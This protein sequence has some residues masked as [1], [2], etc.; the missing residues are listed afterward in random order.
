MLRKKGVVGKFV[1][2]FGPGL[3][4][5]AARRPRDDR[6]H[7]AR[8]RRDRAASS[9]STT[10]RCATCALTGR[11]PSTIALVE[12]YCKEQ[13]LFHEPT[14]PE[15]TYSADRRAR[16]RRRS[17]RASPGRE[18]P[19]DRVPLSDAKHVLRGVARSS[20]CR[21][22]SQDSD[23]RRF[24][25]SDRC[26]Q[27]S[28]R[29]ER[30]AGRPSTAE[31]ARRRRARSPSTRRASSW[32]HGVGRHRRDHEL[33]EHVEPVGDDRGRAARARR[34]SSA[35]LQRKPWVKTSL[36]PGSKVVTEYLD[37]RGP[38]RRTSR[39]SAS[40]SSATAARPASATPARCRADLA[41]R[42]TTGDLVV[43]AVLS[44]NRNFEG[45]IHPEV[46]A[47]YLASPPL[48]VAYALAGRID[49]DLD[50]RA[51]RH[52]TATAS[53]SSC[54]TSGRRREEVET[55]SRRRSEPRCSAH[56]TP[57]SS[58]G[59]ERWRALPVP[60]GRPLR[61]GPGLDLRPPPAVLRRHG[62]RARRRSPTSPARACS[63][64]SATAS[65]PTTSRR[66]ARSSR[67]ARPAST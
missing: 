59:D 20:G 50:A 65:R 13:G 58:T 52:R 55:R 67:T 14:T 66:P 51:A 4:Q 32:T 26:G 23:G 49:I 12:A 44:G 22:R 40:T 28:R 30:A 18:R 1:E 56:A 10:R 36:A 35:G 5:P 6:E 17:S 3:A 24:P 8:V 33:H 2:F 9:R 31:P 48:V 54:A 38:A 19:Q 45:R 41:R 39:S 16:P 42:S 63:R 60:D 62:P 47:N 34:R 25:A 11:E 64:C 7:G 27:P 61:L 46:R 21:E 43:A 29:R 37:A 57:T 15:P 53:R